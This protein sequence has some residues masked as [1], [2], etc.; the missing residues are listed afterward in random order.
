MP[1]VSEAHRVAQKERILEAAIGAVAKKGLT[2]IT[3]ADIIA[4]SQLSA[5]AIYGYYKGKDELLVDLAGRV[6]RQRRETLDALALLDPV[7]RPAEAIRTLVAEIP[8]AWLDS[9]V[10]MQ[11]WGF[12]AGHVEVLT[13]ASGVLAD[14]GSGLGGY[15]MAWLRSTGMDP[16]EARERAHDVTP[17]AAGLLQ[18]YLLQASLMGPAFDSDAYLTGVDQLLGGALSGDR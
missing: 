1:R 5:G 16:A 12:A 2:N 7:P 10:L 18:G 6:M 8:P 3:M 17:V 14:L 9:G 13:M 11:F 4:E 15:L